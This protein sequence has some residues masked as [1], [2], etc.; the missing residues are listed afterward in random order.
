LKTTPFRIL[1]HLAR[2]SN[3]RS[4][5]FYYLLLATLPQLQSKPLTVTH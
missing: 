4:G 5:Q 3:Q 1:I 2:L